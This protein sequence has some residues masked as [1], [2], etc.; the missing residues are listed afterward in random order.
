MP[1]K[2]ARTGKYN[3]IDRIQA[4]LALNDILRNIRRQETDLKRSYKCEFCPFWHH[5]SQA[6]RHNEMAHSA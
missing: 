3:F 2:C 4:D 1:A 6:L 5:T